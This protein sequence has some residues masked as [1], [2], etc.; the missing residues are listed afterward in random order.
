M[1]CEEESIGGLLQMDVC[2]EML[3]LLLTACGEDSYHYPS[4]KLKFLTAYSG[5][6]GALERVLTDDGEEYAVLVDDS[7]LHIRPDFLRKAVSTFEWHK[8][9]GR[10]LHLY[11]VSAAVA[12][13]P[14][15]VDKF[16]E[17]EDWTQWMC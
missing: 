14:L 1:R 8:E 5:G 7:H 17:G 4:V 11:A 15:P 3:C 13:I 12:P 16:P 2:W 6:D 10:R 9:G